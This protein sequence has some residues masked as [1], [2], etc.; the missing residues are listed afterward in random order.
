MCKHNHHIVIDYS[1]GER[2][3]EREREREA[4]IAYSLAI[5][6][7]YFKKFCLRFMFLSLNITNFILK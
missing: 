7:K 1:Y 2:E 5:S 3:R 6:E 4:K